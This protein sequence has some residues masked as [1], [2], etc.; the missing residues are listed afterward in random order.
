MIY[1]IFMN[2]SRYSNKAKT[3]FAEIK[4]D[5]IVHTLS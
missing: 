3:L 4:E 5:Q 1:N 2:N